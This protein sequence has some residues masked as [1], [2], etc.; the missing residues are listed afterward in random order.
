MEKRLQAGERSLSILAQGQVFVRLEL[1]YPGAETELLLAC[2]PGN[3]VFVGENVPRHPQ[4]AS[5][6]LPAKLICA[7]GLDAAL[8]P[9]T[10]APTGLPS[11]KPASEAAGV[12]VVGSPVKK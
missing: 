9:T 10:I 2:C 3:A 8:P 12:S 11:R 6:L 5:L 4:V 1:L 7:A